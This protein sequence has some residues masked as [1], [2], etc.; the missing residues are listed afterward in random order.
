[1]ITEKE[2][3]CVCV[4]NCADHSWTPQPQAKHAHKDR[5]CSEAFINNMSS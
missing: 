1:M 3:K 2:S 4:A 5:N